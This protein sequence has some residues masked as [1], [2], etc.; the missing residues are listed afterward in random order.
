MKDYYADYI[1]VKSQLARQKVSHQ[2]KITSLEK[3]IEKLR[4]QIARPFKPQM[5]DSTLENLLEIVCSVTGI[6]PIE[7]CSK[8]RNREYIVARHL[9]FYIAIRHMNLTVSKVGLFMKRHHATVIHGKNAYQDYIDMGYQPEC[10]YYNEAMEML[11][12]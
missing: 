11:G 8:Y 7:I 1:K 3:E 2:N 12:S 6:L 4:N 5:I 10:S 9:F